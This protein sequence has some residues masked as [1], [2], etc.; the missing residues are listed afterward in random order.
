VKGGGLAREVAALYA[1]FGAWRKFYAGFR[2]ALSRFDLV[3]HLLPPGGRV[4]DLG[5]GYGVVSNYLALAS[6]TRTVIGIDWD[7]KRIGVARETVRGRANPQF[8]QGDVVRLELPAADVV[9]MNDFLHHLDPEDQEAVLTRLARVLAPDAM[10]LIQEVNTRPRWKFWCS[11]LSD[12]VLYRFERGRFRA[13]E[14]WVALLSRV[15]F[16]RVEIVQ[17]DAGSIFARVSY[18]ARR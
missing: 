12:R 6:P 5:C 3:E 10:L 14:E 8:I 11:Y 18:I 13:P 1:P 16:P 2:V 4:L 9:L 17:G 7:Q 15:G